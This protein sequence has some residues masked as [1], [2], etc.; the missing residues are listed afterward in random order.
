MLL[1]VLTDEPASTSKLYDRVGYAT[2]VS[3]GLV[4]Y[5]AFRAELAKLVAAGL[6]QSGADEDGATVWRLR[7]PPE[8]EEHDDQA[9]AAR[10]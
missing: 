1:A 8:P 3:H 6:A 9:A 5:D 2:L 4:P 7:A 10:L